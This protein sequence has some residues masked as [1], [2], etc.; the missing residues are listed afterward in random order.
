MTKVY[1]EL[2]KPNPSTAIGK[3]KLEDIKLSILE[4]NISLLIFDDDLTPGQVR[5]LEN[6]LQIKV[7]D[8]SGLILDIFA[9][10]AQ[11]LEAKNSSRSCSSS[12]STSKVNSY[13]DSPFKTVWW[14]W[15]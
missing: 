12:I 6:E 3:G 10:H 4:N 13:V 2:V 5:N 15:Y 8:R 9:R 14:Y 11:S 1:Q 7:I